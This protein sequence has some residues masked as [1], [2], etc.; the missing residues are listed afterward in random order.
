MDVKSVVTFPN[1]DRGFK[2][3]GS[4]EISGLAW[5]GRG[6]IARV[7]VSVDGGATWGPT[8]LQEPVLSK[9]L[10]R[11]RLPFTWHGEPLE[12]QSRAFDDKGWVQP[13]RSSLIAARGTNPR[14]HFNAIQGWKIA[15]NGAVSNAST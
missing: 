2:A 11:F 8:V 6:R 1:S 9:C 4:Y 12:I 10:T 3:A 13:T 15:A 7:D 14:Y 5:S